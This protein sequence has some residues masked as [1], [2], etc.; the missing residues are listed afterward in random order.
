MDTEVQYDGSMNALEG[1]A[2]RRRTFLKNT[3][4]GM[5]TFAGTSLTSMGA[6]GLHANES[7]DREASSGS[8]A[9]ESLSG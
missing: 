7:E 3:V 2:M 1:K 6:E 8:I 5:A 9:G 4:I